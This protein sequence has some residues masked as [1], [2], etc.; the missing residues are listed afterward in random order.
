[1]VWI[2][3]AW[4]HVLYPF[5]AAVLIAYVLDPLMTCCA[6]RVHS[7]SLA[8]FLI[9]FGLGVVFFLMAWGIFPF[10]KVQ[11]YAL[12]HK[13]PS[14]MHLVHKTLLNVMSYVKGLIPESL[15]STLLMQG[16][17]PTLDLAQWGGIALQQF[18]GGGNR[19]INAFACLVLLPLVL[20]FLL[21]DGSR[22]FEYLKGLV[23]K[24]YAKDVLEQL[25]E[26]DRVVSGFLR[27]QAKIALTLGI[28][29]VF[30]LSFLGLDFALVI[31]LGTGV[32]SFLPYVGVAVGLGVSLLV[33]FYQFQSLKMLLIILAV[34]LVAQV[35][36]TLFLSPRFVAKR[37]NLHPLWVLLSLF[38]G[39][40]LYGMT[41]AF[42]AIPLASMVGVLGRFGVRAYRDHSLYLG[43]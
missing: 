29:Y 7:R 19:V 21:R 26:M 38:V 6:V 43:D 40:S 16:G 10:L 15:S 12:A 31:G 8:A 27:G 30:C 35:L 39:G 41:G 11:L 3:L 1:M 2:L 33:G 37:V 25:G 14:Y 18:L 42:L 4:S 13:L 32:L 22:G 17:Q 5:I 20:F 9:L 24:K 23:P 34:F 36:D 28:F